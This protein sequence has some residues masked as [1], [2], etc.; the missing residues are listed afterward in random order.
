M[1]PKPVDA[2]A[3]RPTRHLECVEDHVSAH[4]RGNAPADDHAAER[5]DDEA[6][7][8]DTGPCRHVGQ[9]R[10]PQRVRSRRTELSLDEVRRSRRCRV[11]TCRAQPA[12]AGDATDAGLAHE[13]GDL[14]TA[15]LMTGR[16]ARVDGGREFAE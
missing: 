14:V 8:R 6:H 4:V 9:V 3:A 10:D 2:R 11:G 1:A 15:D 16:N 7:V 13:P 12:L 5:V